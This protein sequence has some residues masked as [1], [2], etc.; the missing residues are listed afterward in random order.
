M[1]KTVVNLVTS[2]SEQIYSAAFRDR[3]K[4]ITSRYVAQLHL[5]PPHLLPRFGHAFLLPTASVPLVLLVVLFY[6]FPQVLSTLGLTG[7]FLS[8][9]VACLYTIAHKMLTHFSSWY[10]DSPTELQQQ[11]LGMLFF[12]SVRLF[13]TLNYHNFGVI[14]RMTIAG[15]SGP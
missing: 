14:N 4:L 10:S 6:Q 5:S 13:K 7:R 8:A 2:N 15:M 3:A 1:P 11:R 9:F 12:F